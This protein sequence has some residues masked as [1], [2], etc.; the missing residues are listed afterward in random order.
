[1][2]DHLDPPNPQPLEPTRVAAARWR[3]VLAA[4]QAQTTESREA[5]TRLCEVY[6]YPL[7]AYVRRWGYN[8]DQ[9]RDLTQEFFGRLLEAQAIGD[10]DPSRG[11]FRS[12]LLASLKHFLANERDRSSALKRGGKTTLVALE[13]ESAEGMYRQEPPDPETPDAIF[14]RRWALTL[15]ERTLTRLRDECDE[16]G[17][18]TLFA[19]LERYLTGE[20]ETVPYA[21]LV[22]ELGMTEGA[23]KTAVQRLRRRFGTLLRDEIGD[24]VCDPQEVDDEIREL[25]RILTER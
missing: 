2:T 15:L 1:M 17:K 19:R 24:T 18:S 23:V 22:G 11:R 16:S 5:L 7:Y 14:Q 8:A 3:R 21:G 25:F 13:Q 4:G 6:W 20:Q 12:F 9:A 10:A